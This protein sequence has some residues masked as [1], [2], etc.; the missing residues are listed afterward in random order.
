LVTLVV[1]IVIIV[2]RVLVNDIERRATVRVVGA[3]VKVS[4]NA[5]GSLVLGFVVDVV[6]VVHANDLMVVVP[7]IGLWLH[8][9]R[10]TVMN[11]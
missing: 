8:D 1:A 7:V 9:R 6:L 10:Y 3:T 2:I 11:G 5:G 4:Q